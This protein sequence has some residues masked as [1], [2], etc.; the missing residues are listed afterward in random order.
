VGFDI[1]LPYSPVPSPIHSPTSTSEPRT[2]SPLGRHGSSSPRD[3]G[4]PLPPPV[5]DDMIWRDPPPHDAKPQPREPRDGVPLGVKWVDESGGGEL[6]K[7]GNSSAYAQSH[8]LESLPTPLT[9]CLIC[10]KNPARSERCQRCGRCELCARTIFCK[11]A[12]KSAR[13]SETGHVNKLSQCMDRAIWEAFRTGQY[14]VVL[15]LIKNAGVH[16]NF[17]R[18]HRGETAIMAAAYNGNDAV[19]SE[20]LALGADPTLKT[21]EGYNAAYFAQQRGHPALAERINSLIS[22]AAVV[23]SQGEKRAGEDLEGAAASKKPKPDP[24]S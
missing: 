16:V 2:R 24:G 1:D 18:A 4:S 20:L 6:P 17:R 10:N 19:F 13:S 11:G 23:A 22:G 14:D 9:P 21:A 12:E 5:D 8:F 3:D 7:S 15:S